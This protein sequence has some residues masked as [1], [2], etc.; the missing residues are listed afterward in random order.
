MIPEAMDKS[1]ADYKIKKL[2]QRQLKTE[3][4]KKVGEEASALPNLKSKNEIKKELADVVAVINEIK[5]IYKISDKEIKKELKK[6]YKKK[7]G[8]KKRLYLYW[9]SNTGYKTNERRYDKSEV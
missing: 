9:S 5:K 8:F 1:G 2:N 6:A 3:L 7:G 4:L